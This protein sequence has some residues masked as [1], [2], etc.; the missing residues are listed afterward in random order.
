MSKN[1]KVKKTNKTPDPFDAGLNA[2]QV[3]ADTL[4]DQFLKEGVD[5]DAIN[6]AFVAAFD[7]LSYRMLQIF[8]KEVVFKILG[9]MASS[10][11]DDGVHV[12]ND[13]QDEIDN[14]NLEE[15]KNKMH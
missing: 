1:K 11:E 2:E 10:I 13:C 9:K 7:S 6:K 4:C 3:L 15:V 12:C 8:G 14:G 5:K